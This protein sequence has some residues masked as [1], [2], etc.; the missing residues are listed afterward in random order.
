MHHQLH[1]QNINKKSLLHD[2]KGFLVII[3]AEKE[4]FEPSVPLPVHQLSKLAHSTT[5][6]SLRIL[7]GLQK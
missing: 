4:G 7:N 3:K 6:T 1:R 2:I 5:L